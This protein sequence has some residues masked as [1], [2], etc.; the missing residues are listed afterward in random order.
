MYIDPQELGNVAMCP[1]FWPRHIQCLPVDLLRRRPLAGAEVFRPRNVCT[2]VN[3]C[4]HCGRY[5]CTYLYNSIII[6]LQVWIVIIITILY[7]YI[8]TYIYYIIIHHHS[9]SFYIDFTI[10]LDGHWI[11]LS[12]GRWHGSLRSIVTGARAGALPWKEKRYRKA[13]PRRW[14]LIMVVF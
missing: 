8:C 11:A 6:I 7:I 9:K 13:P 2:F 10:I 12:Q 4:M 1:T 14:W 5:R 3:L